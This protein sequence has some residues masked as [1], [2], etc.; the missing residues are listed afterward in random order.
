MILQIINTL[1]N[2]H[3]EKQM[4]T[5]PFTDEHYERLQQEYDFVAQTI[6]HL[7]EHFQYFAVSN[8]GIPN[9]DEALR[10]LTI[11]KLKLYAQIDFLRNYLV[12]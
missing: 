1:F 2:N 9:A 10:Q 11:E 3:K 4:S 12:N 8:G 5:N 6:G 7:R